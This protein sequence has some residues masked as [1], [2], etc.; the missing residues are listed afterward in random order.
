MSAKKNQARE[1]EAELKILQ[2]R[3]K[4]LHLRHERTDRVRHVIRQLKKSV[5][6]ALLILASALAI[7]IVSPWPFLVTLK[8]IAAF[9]NCEAARLVNL[10]PSERGAAGYYSRHDGDDDGVACESF[11]R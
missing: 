4:A 7:K 5:L 2:D 6:T 9:P 10:A 1:P 3:F 8:H 11:K